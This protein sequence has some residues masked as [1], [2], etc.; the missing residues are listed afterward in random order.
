MK[1]YP[2]LK[3]EP[4]GI[5]G[6]LLILLLAAGPIGLAGCAVNPVTGQSEYLLVSEDMEVALGQQADQEIRDQYGVYPDQKLAKYVDDI[7]QKIAAASHRPELKYYYTVLDTPVINAFALPGGYVYITRGLLAYLNNEAELASVLGHETGHISAKHGAKQLSTTLTFQV[8]SL[9]A[10]YII[11]GENVDQIRQAVG[12]VVAL[13]I[14]GYGRE[15]EFQA[16]Q[17]GENYSAKIG[18]DP[19]ATADFLGTLKRLEGDE[20]PFFLS[21]LLASHPPTKERIAK[22]QAEDQKLEVEVS[23]TQAPN[24]PVAWQVNGKKYLKSLDGLLWGFPLAQGTIAGQVYQNKTYHCG[25][26]APKDWKIDNSNRS[27]LVTMT[28]PGQDR[29][30]LLEAEDVAKNQTPLGLAQEKEKTFALTKKEEKDSWF[31]GYAGY[32]A[33]YQG[34]VEGRDLAAVRLYW[35]YKGRGYIFSLITTLDK[36]PEAKEDF[37]NIRDSFW[38]LKPGEEAAIREKHIRIYTVKAGDSWQSL[39][40]KN[41]DKNATDK[42]K[43]ICVLNGYE[44]DKFPAPGTLVKLLPD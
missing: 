34:Q 38:V 2:L 28:G 25:L 37:K 5:A 26:V 9:G 19:T 27:F 41:S 35:I 40:D 6:G 7:G 20:E 33:Y 17:L 18:Y 21:Q 29:Q 3:N 24:Q 42:V 10:S 43:K 8:L 4:G 44:P 11:K 31:N 13:G 32:L 22:A 1:K 39:A 36:Y 12:V 15:N 30:F 23:K 16:D 14:L